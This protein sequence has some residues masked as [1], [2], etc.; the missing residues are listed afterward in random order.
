MIY[1]ATRSGTGFPQGM[2]PTARVRAY[3]EGL[4]SAGRQVTVLC[5]SPSERPDAKASPEQTSG[6]YRG[7]D[8][9]YTCGSP[10]YAT[11]R[12][13][14]R[15]QLMRGTMTAGKI[16]ADRARDFDDVE[17]VILYPESLPSA[18]LMQLT[19]RRYGFPLILEKSELPEVHRKRG[20]WSRI[21]MP[22][23]VR[24]VYRLF[25]GIIVISAPL[26]EFFAPLLRKS[27]LLLQVPILVDP[28]YLDTVASEREDDNTKQKYV[29]YCGSLSERKDGVL[30]LIRAFA[31]SC[32]VEDG[33]HL[34][35]VGPA[36]S[37][38]ERERCADLVRTLGL[39]GRVTLTGQLSRDETRQWQLR[40]A[41]LVLPRP[42]SEQ[43]RTGMPT[44]LAEYL[45]SG[46]PVVMTN[47]GDQSRLLTDG[48]H[49]FIVPPGDV[50][51]LGEAI[52]RVLRCPEAAELMAQRGRA[53]ALREFDCNAHGKRISDFIGRC[54]KA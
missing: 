3:A 6:V 18:L 16:I 22:L 9:R 53:F 45:A 26:Q 54:S 32:T 34:V 30:T 27:A 5:M 7:T 51:Q 23:Y 20:L 4:R 29:V 2:A 11:G 36:A 33:A 43:A 48:T 12:V 47:L 25:D 39:A 44:K 40:A 15:V 14:R 13:R 42:M 8:Y 28:E 10:R 35:L 49:S 37:R 17:A 38:M 21:T 52:S 24:V 31:R 41:V 1:I 46:R 19:A 50:A